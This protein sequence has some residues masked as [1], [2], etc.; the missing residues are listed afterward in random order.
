MNIYDGTVNTTATV[1]IDAKT[2]T[3]S[4]GQSSEATSYTASE[5]TQRRRFP[6]KG[7]AV[8]APFKPGYF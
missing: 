1:D 3:S 6:Q 2:T 7:L 4:D 5:L 8:I